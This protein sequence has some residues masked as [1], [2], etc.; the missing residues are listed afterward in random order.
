M[1]DLQTKCRILQFQT[2]SSEHSVL[3]SGVWS[4]LSMFKYFMITLHAPSNVYTVTAAIISAVNFSPVKFVTCV[5][6]FSL[7]DT[8]TAQ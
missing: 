3:S 8:A 2:I 6:E 5:E 1:G 4:C 7:P